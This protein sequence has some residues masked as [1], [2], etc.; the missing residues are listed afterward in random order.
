MAGTTIT[1]TAQDPDR[2]LD[3]ICKEII[4]IRDNFTPDSAII[5]YNPTTN[6]RR[7]FEMQY[8]NP[9]CDDDMEF[10]VVETAN[11]G[12]RAIFAMTVAHHFGPEVKA[13]EWIGTV[14]LHT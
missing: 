14:H 4:E 10:R 8:V 5:L 12:P 3:Q 13:G 7:L 2:L 9:S 11:E 1:R 6:E